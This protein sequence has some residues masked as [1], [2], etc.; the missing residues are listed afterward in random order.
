MDF[1][2][3][4]EFVLKTCIEVIKTSPKARSIGVDEY[5]L[6]QALSTTLGIPNFRLQGEYHK[7]TCYTGM[8]D[9]IHDL[10]AIGLIE[11]NER[12]EHHWKIS[13]LGYQHVTDQ[14]LL[15]STICQEP[16][17][18]EHAQLLSIVN[19]LSPHSSS[20]HGW[21]EIIENSAIVSDLQSW[22][23][24]QVFNVARELKEWGYVSG[25]FSAADTFRLTATYK[26]L[27]WENKR[28]FTV[29]AK[30]IEDLLEEGETTSVDFKR[31]LHLDTADEKAEFVKDI[32]SLAN[33][34]ASGHRWMIIG[35][36]DK[37]HAYYA[38]PDPGSTQNRIEQILSV[39]TTP[40]VDVR[41][42]IINYRG[43]NVG[44]LEVLREPRKLPYA[45]AKSLGGKKHI[46]QNNIYV[47][48]GSQ[49]Q[50]PT[51]EELLALHEEGDIARAI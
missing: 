17:D 34:K 12:S 13:R 2:E 48:H 25:F 20:D 47:R 29:T 35:F 14:I 44:K 27:V 6:A 39:Y 51:P 49:V 23:L 21:L 31:E 28:G 3:W 33:T 32:L 1:V 19:H 45:V 46:E 26:G 11:N 10:K 22:P 30:F 38:S 9:A 15:W 41:Y 43:G 16:I 42:E 50:P 5:E 4:C 18:S 40:S 8:F 36:D 7:S 24:H 37:S